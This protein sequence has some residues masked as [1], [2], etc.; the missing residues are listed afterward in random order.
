MVSVSYT[1]LDVYKRQQSGRTQEISRLIGRSLRA[2]LDDTALG[3]NT[4]QIDCDVLQADGGTRTAAITGAYVALADALEWA[5]DRG[6]IAA[7][8]KPLIDSVAAVS[9]GIIDG[10]P[11]LDLHYDDDVSA[12]TDMNVVMTGGG[13]YVEG[14]GVVRHVDQLIPTRHTSLDELDKTRASLLHNGQPWICSECI[15]IGPAGDG[16]SGTDDPHVVAARGA[17]CAA[18]CG[19]ADFNHRHVV[20]FPS[21]PQNGSTGRVA[22]NDQHLDAELDLMVH[23]VQRVEANLRNRQRTVRTVE[24][25]ADIEDCLVG[26]LIQ[27]GARNGEPTDPR[28]ENPNWRL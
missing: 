19:M 15:R 14:V 28:V 1:H 11:R 21:V 4:I 8:S 18:D 26:K 22:R 25:V 17:N 24:G 16:G 9:V 20:P 13:K 12:Q 23:N 27:D 3:E 2:A 7:G 6:H 5:R 10:Q